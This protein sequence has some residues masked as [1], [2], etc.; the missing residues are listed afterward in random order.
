PIYGR[1]LELFAYELLYR[2]DYVERAVVRSEDRSTAEVFLN[3][4]QSM[5]L[6]QLLGNSRAFVNMTRT[7]I[8]KEYCTALPKE[9]VVLEVL[10]NVEPDEEVVRS[11]AALSAGGYSIALDDFVYSEEKRPLLEVADYVKVDF[12]A[13]STDE[14]FQQ[15]PVLKAH[16]L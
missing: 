9:R 3:T 6:E 4:F 5:G 11:L 7:F 14:I 8:V 12:R 10:E 13:L 15:I 1:A 16:H 2:D